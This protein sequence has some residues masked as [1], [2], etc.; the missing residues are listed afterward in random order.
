[1]VKMVEKTGKSQNTAK[2]LSY[3][4]QRIEELQVLNDLFMN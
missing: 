2:S 1:M 4:T 3:Y